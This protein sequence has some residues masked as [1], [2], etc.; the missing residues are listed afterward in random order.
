[1][2]FFQ[3]TL[4]LL[5][6]FSGPV[7]K[8]K[9]VIRKSFSFAESKSDNLLIVRNING[10][11]KITGHDKNTVELVL[12]KTISGETTEIIADGKQEVQLGIIEKEKTIFLYMDCPCTD[13]RI[14]ALTTDQ[15]RN[16]KFQH[17]VNNCNWKPRYDYHFDFE[18]KVPKNIM[19]EAS[20]INEGDLSVEG[21]SGVVSV[22]NIN[23][24][25]S[26]KQIAGP[27][28]V[29]AINGDVDLLYS[30][31]PSDACSYYTLNG[32]IKVSFVRGLSA[33]VFFE[34]FNGELFT[35]IDE[36]EALPANVAQEAVENG[37][38]IKYKLSSNPGIKIRQGGLALHFET[39][40]GNVYIKEQ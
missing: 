34:S 14:G 11:I 22:N 24:D 38:G 8:D 25:I 4:A 31:N 40:N 33:D 15:I 10:G 39:F 27:T 1:M 21:V 6:V 18:L 28:D 16:G 5:L 12:T 7:Q 17:W 19:V 3:I 36:V 23:G 29:H 13:E 32:D 37:K 26:L 20:T 30:K 9:E 2:P 35:D